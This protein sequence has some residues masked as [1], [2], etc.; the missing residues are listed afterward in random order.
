MSPTDQ[1]EHTCRQARNSQKLLICVLVPMVLRHFCTRSA[2]A[3]RL[4]F[5]SLCQSVLPTRLIVGFSR[6]E[7]TG[8]KST[9]RDRQHL[10]CKWLCLVLFLCGMGMRW[11][12]AQRG[13]NSRRG[14]KAE[15][16]QHQTDTSCSML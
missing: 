11:A 1:A 5:F 2:A 12:R 14:F 13:Q 15:I 16:S 10:L 4:T 9:L 3:V 6:L 8:L 7:M